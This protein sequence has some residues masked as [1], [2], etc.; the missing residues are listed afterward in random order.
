MILGA[1]RRLAQAALTLAAA[2]VL[3]WCLQE[4][5]PVD[6]ARAVLIAQGITDPTAGQVDRLRGDLG[7]DDPA[8]VRFVRWAGGL[9]RGDLGTSW[10]TGTAVSAELASR[11]PATLRLGA[12][13][14]LLAA[15]LAVPAALVAA[16]WR[17]GPVD[18]GVRGLI[19]A[20]AAVP[21][22]VIGSVLLH[23]VVL[24][25]G[26]GTVLADGSWTTALM[27]ALPLAIGAAAIWARVFRGSLVAASSARTVD[28][29]VARG[30]GQWRALLI[31]VVPPATPAL[32][33][34]VG[35]TV[36]GLLAGAAVVETIFTWPG[37]GRYLVE[38]VVARDAP[39]VQALVLFGVLAYVA[40]SLVVDLIVLVVRR[41]PE[42]AG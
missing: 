39:V 27:P 20:G 5:A 29:A 24:D 3:V 41:Q 23:I 36:G 1:L 21:S 32:L 38:A 19:F 18:L 2:A 26:I 35:I 17:N 11:L 33:T 7:L 37:L 12:V 16:R 13:A 8:Y 14:L 34:A 28:V 40:T 30:A 15:L 25:W 10:S 31:H 42:Q 9:I 6:P 4:L 22:F